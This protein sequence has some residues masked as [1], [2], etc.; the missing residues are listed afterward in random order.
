MSFE[1]ISEISLPALSICVDKSFLLKP[2][3]LTQLGINQTER[4][5]V[6]NNKKIQQFFENITIKEQFNVMNGKES[7]FSKC[8]VSSPS[9]FAIEYPYVDCEKISA[10]KTSITMY[11]MCFTFFSQT[12]GQSDESF[13]IDF[14][15]RKYE[16]FSKELIYW[17]IRQNI[18][19]IHLFVHSRKELIKPMPPEAEGISFSPSNQ[20]AFFIKYRRVITRSLPLPFDTNCFEYRNEEYI[21]EKG[22]IAQCRLKGWLS[23]HPNKWRGFNPATN[24][25]DLIMVNVFANRYKYKNRTFDKEIKIKCQKECKSMTN[26]YKEDFELKLI[27]YQYNSDTIWVKILPPT[28]PDQVIQHIPK[29]SFEEFVIFIGSLIG[30]YFGF[31]IIMLSNVCSV[32]FK[33]VVQN[34]SINQ[35]LNTKLN[36][37]KNINTIVAK[38]DL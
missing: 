9:S 2:K 25:S 35:Y 6:K 23:V 4:F 28:I 32:A 16:E 10:I 19:F 37:I 33:Y 30:L 21:S 12:D 22:C 31:S 18:S 20:F 29:I 8:K 3:Y 7:V 34:I 15:Q 24:S 11:F 17:N 14:T 1:N 26:C 5:S 38:T 13:K 27:Q 36:S